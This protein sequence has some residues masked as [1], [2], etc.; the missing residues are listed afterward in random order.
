M[1]GFSNIHHSDVF[2][3][4]KSVLAKTSDV[5][6]ANTKDTSLDPAIDSRDEYSGNVMN[7][8]GARYS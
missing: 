8:D 6:F 2:S 1:D 4:W 3:L 7:E 5:L